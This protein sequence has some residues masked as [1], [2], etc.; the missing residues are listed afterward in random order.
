VS[1]FEKVK[2]AFSE[3]LLHGFFDVAGLILICGVLIVIIYV[4]VKDGLGGSTV[5]GV[6][7]DLSVPPSA[8]PAAWIK[9]NIGGKLVKVRYDDNLLACFRTLINQRLTMTIGTLG[10][11]LTVRHED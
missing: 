4:A 10:V 5:T 3:S 11:V 8:T 2:A 9:L 1:E 7:L 6:L